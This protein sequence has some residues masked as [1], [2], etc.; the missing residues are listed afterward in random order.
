M[1]LAG[2]LN[3]AIGEGFELGLLQP[4]TIEAAYTNQLLIWVLCVI[5]LVLSG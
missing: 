1:N 3:Q 5:G 4:N 2:L